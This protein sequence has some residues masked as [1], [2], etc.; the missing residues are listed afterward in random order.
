MDARE[1]FTCRRPR[2]THLPAARAKL[3]RKSVK[4]L[5][6]LRALRMTG[7]RGVLSEAWG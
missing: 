4:H 2:F 3:V 5:G 7:R 6:P 1:F